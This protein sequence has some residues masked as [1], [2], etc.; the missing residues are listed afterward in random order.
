MN[1][2]LMTA[3]VDFLA[4]VEPSGDEVINPDAAMQAEENAAYTLQALSTRDR[5]VLDTHVR[6]MAAQE[7][8][9][10]R[11]EFLGSLMGALGLDSSEE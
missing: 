11:A 4:F 6:S 3:L 8:D 1:P 7:R 5:A 9:S 2:T 10:R